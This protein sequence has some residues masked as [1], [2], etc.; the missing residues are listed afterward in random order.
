MILQHFFGSLFCCEDTFLVPVP[1]SCTPTFWKR[2]RRWICWGLALLSCFQYQMCQVRHRL[3]AAFSKQRTVSRCCSWRALS[4]SVWIVICF[5]HSLKCN[6]VAASGFSHSGAM[7][8]NASNNPWDPV[9]EMLTRG[10]SRWWG[11]NEQLEIAC[12]HC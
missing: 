3:D 6:L 7:V 9:D 2:R 8:M 4:F 12:R 1:S 5:T 11:K 10:K